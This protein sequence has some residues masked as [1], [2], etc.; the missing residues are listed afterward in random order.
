[1]KRVIKA[2]LLISWLILIF[3]FS[4]QNADASSELS[5]G[6]LALFF[7]D[8]PEDSVLYLLIR[9]LAHFFLFFILALIVDTNAK[10]YFRNHYLISLIV[11]I[12]YCVSDEIHQSFVPGREC[13]II[14]MLIDTCAGI[15]ALKTKQT[16][17][18][19]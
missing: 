15:I 11:V 8:L 13:M 19:S 3:F 7:K 14:D 16:I 2:L 1:M 5:N 4:S 18:R 6:L 12:I 10:E 9:K 17:Y